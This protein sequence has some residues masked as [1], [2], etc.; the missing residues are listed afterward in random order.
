MEMR[1]LMRRSRNGRCDPHLI[2]AEVGVSIDE[3][4]A[5]VAA[6]E[7]EGYIARKQ[8]TDLTGKKH[9]FWENTIK[10]NSLAMA[11]AARPVKRRT[12]ETAVRDLLTRVA[13][14]NARADLAYRVVRITLFGSYLSQAPELNDVDLL[15]DLAPRISSPALQEVLEAQVRKRAISC[16]RRFDSFVDELAWPETEVHMLLKNR[17]RVLSLHYGDHALVRTCKNRVLF[18]TKDTDVPNIRLEGIP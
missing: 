14:V 17:S 4:A 16:G 5:V 13:A 2:S 7:H 1:R 8:S 10:G 12:A 9:T 18:E 11:T 6:L 15:V 3:A